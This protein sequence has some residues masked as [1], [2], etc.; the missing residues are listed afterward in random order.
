M[1]K[2][3]R[4]KIQLHRFL[5][6]M[7]LYRGLLGL[8]NLKNKQQDVG[9]FGIDVTTHLKAKIQQHKKLPIFTNSYESK[10]GVVYATGDTNQP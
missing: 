6:Y 3:W 7:H 5:Q 10:N 4:R 2:G 1:G 9:L 8:L